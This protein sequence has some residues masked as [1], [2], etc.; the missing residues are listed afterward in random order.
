M[1]AKRKAKAVKKEKREHYLV[2]HKALEEFCKKNK[3]SAVMV[4]CMTSDSVET[5]AEGVTLANAMRFVPA[6]STLHK[7]TLAIGAA[8][9]L[10]DFVGEVKKENK[11]KKKA[12]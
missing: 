5:H 4:I 10:S 2:S 7:K 11:G 6:I 3:I 1:G 9:L 8:S 12:K